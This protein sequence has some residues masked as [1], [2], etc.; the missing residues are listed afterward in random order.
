MI[1]QCKSVI[2]FFLTDEKYLLSFLRITKFNVDQACARFE[3]TCLVSKIFPAYYD[4][5]IDK[6]FERSLKFFSGG[7]VY[8]L[9]YRDELGRKVLVMRQGKRDCDE[10]SSVDVLKMV[11][12]AVTMAME[13]E[14][15]QIAGFILIIDYEDMTLKHMLSPVDMKV[16]MDVLKTCVGM[17]HKQYLLVNMSKVSQMAVELCKTFMS[18]KMKNRL[19]IINDKSELENHIKS[20]SCLPKELGGETPE[21]ELIADFIELLKKNRD[22]FKKSWEAEIDWDKVPEEKLSTE[23]YH[24]DEIGSFRKLQID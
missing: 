1:N 16:A 9:R 14:E 23:N 19:T 15:N 10:F 11:R 13:D 2:F 5:D 12:F 7:F 8:P 22:I 6:E 4:I 3:R 20:L 24:F 21:A 17:R 18:E